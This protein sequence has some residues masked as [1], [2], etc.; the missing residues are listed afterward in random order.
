MRAMRKL[1]ALYIGLALVALMGLGYYSL[2]PEPPIT[3]LLVP[4]DSRPVNTQHVALLT[5]MAGWEIVMPPLALLDNFTTPSDP[6]QLISW[7]EEAI[8]EADIVIA[9]AN[10]LIAGGLIASRHLQAFTAWEDRVLAVGDI[11]AQHPDKITYVINVLPRLSPTQFDNEGWYYQQELTQYAKLYDQIK[12]GISNEHMQRQLEEIKNHLPADILHQYTALY[13]LDRALS[14]HLIEYVEAGYIDH[15]VLTLDDA[16]PY[17]LSNLNFRQLQQEVAKRGLGHHISFL[18]GADETDMLTVARIANDLHHTTPTFLPIYQEKGHRQLMMPFEASPLHIILE[19]KI[20]Y[21]GGMMVEHAST[22]LYIHAEEGASQETPYLIQNALVEG[23]RVGVIDI[24]YT[25]RADT[26]FVHQLINVVGLRGIH[27]YG[28][29]NTASNSIGSVVAHLSIISSGDQKAHYVLKVLEMKQ[30]LQSR[31]WSLPI[32]QVV[33]ADLSYRLI[34]WADAYAYQANVRNH[35]I[36]WARN[37]QLNPH[38]FGREYKDVV[39]TQLHAH[40]QPYLVE[41]ELQFLGNHQLTV[42]GKPISYT[43]TD[44]TWDMSLPWPR[45]FEVSLVPQLG[46]K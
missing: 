37:H 4:L 44:L 12:Q 34:H 5:T 31:L 13:Q 18:H 17:G 24:A 16:A 29:W 3:L 8:H 35:L 2:R 21:V 20:A 19:E 32:M 1:M 15:L 7:L 45:V 26:A 10:T 25:N 40:M 36:A 23:K 30:W 14:E 11:F 41:L 46:I 42:D 6:D 43:L 9:Y 33:Q 39:E 38:D 27:S 22:Q 28:G